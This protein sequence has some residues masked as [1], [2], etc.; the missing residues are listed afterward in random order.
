MVLCFST[1]HSLAARSSQLATGHYK[2]MRSRLRFR[3]PVRVVSWRLVKLRCTRGRVLVF[4]GQYSADSII[5]LAFIFCGII[6]YL[7]GAH[8]CSCVLFFIGV[9]MSTTKLATLEC[10]TYVGTVCRT[11]PC[12]SCARGRIHKHCTRV[13]RSPCKY[14]ILGRRF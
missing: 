7:Y 2:T 6:I 12:G 14:L 9:P 1:R 3:I 8:C 10:S 5:R 11:P 4:V 13:M